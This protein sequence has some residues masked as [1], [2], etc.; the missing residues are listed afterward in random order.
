[1]SKS[2]LSV[3]ETVAL[4]TLLAQVC[5]KTDSGA[6]YADNWS[7]EAVLRE[8]QKTC[9]KATINNVAGMRKQFFGSFKKI[10]R[11]N[12][13][14]LIQKVHTLG[15][16]TVDLCKKLENAIKRVDHLEKH[17]KSLEQWAAT[18]PYGKKFAPN[19][20]EARLV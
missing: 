20:D 4:H 8:F 6:V 17:I 16:E 7:D 14:D 12:T 13:K 5:T 19:G 15:A 1:M 11:L 3:V 10:E 18:N 2:Y 9:D